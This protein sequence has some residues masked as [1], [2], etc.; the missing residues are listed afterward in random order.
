MLNHGIN[1]NQAQGTHTAHWG[2]DGAGRPSFASR[3]KGSQTSARLANELCLAM[4]QTSGLRGSGVVIKARTVRGIHRKFLFPIVR[5][6]MIRHFNPAER[7]VTLPP[8]PW[9]KRMSASLAHASDWEAILTAQGSDQNISRKPD[10]SVSEG[11]VAITATESP[12]T[13]MVLLPDPIHERGM[14]L[15]KACSSPMPTWSC[16]SCIEEEGM[17]DICARCRQLSGTHLT[18]ARSPTTPVAQPTVATSLSR[19]MM[20]RDL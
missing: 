18:T 1:H 10:S 8:S 5:P 12:P 17:Y 3:N 7:S 16:A 19:L 13:S 4:S 2:V 9:S 11:F 14:P 20:Q 15:P 6:F